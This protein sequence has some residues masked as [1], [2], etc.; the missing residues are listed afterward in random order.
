MYQD[1]LVGIVEDGAEKEKDVGKAR[2][3]G[4]EK[5]IAKEKEKRREKESGKEKERD[6][7]KDRES[8]KGMESEKEKDVGDGEGT[9][10]AESATFRSLVMSLISLEKWTDL[11]QYDELNRELLAGRLL[12]GFTAA[13]PSFPP[14]FKR[15]RH[16]HIP[17]LLNTDLIE[18]SYTTK[19]V[20]PPQGLYG[21]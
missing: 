10:I 5:E 12:P 11:L 19:D 15:S 3:S 9:P 21:T 1:S 6:K 2:E 17:K 13:M 4:K 7:K 18:K 8:G 20:I 16:L 14:T